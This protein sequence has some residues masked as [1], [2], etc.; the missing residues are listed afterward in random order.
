[1]AV[2]LRPNNKKALRK[3][4]KGK[5]QHAVS[6]RK[7]DELFVFGYGCKLF[8]DFEKA[9]FMEQ[10]KHLIEWPGDDSLLIDRY[11]GRLLFTDK[12]QFEPSGR[13]SVMTAEEIELEK[14]CDEERYLELTRDLLEDE[15]QQEE[16]MKRFKEAL[17]SDGAYNAVGF[18]YGDQQQG[19][20]IQDQGRASSFEDANEQTSMQPL[21]K[22][23]AV[24][25]F[26]APEDLEVPPGME[27]P[28]T[29][30]MNAI[31]EK[32]ALF[33][34]KQGTQMEILVKAKQAGNPQFDFLNFDNW[35]NPYYKHMLK[36][37]KEK[38]YEPKIQTQPES[39]EQQEEESEQEDS[40]DEYEL[41]PLLT[42]SLKT[43]A[44][45]Y[46]SAPSSPSTQQGDM[47]TQPQTNGADG[48]L[49]THP[50]SS[51]EQQQAWHHD[52]MAYPYDMTTT[53][54]A[55]P[56]TYP[57]LTAYHH[58]H[59]H[60]QAPPIMSVADMIPPPPPPPGEGP[61]EEEWLKEGVGSPS[62]PVTPPP[63]PPALPLIPHFL[64]DTQVAVPLG[65]PYP[66]TSHATPTIIPPPPDLQ[67]I[68][69]KLARYVA[70]NG[71]DFESIIKAKGDPRFDFVLPWNEHHA[72]YQFRIRTCAE[73]FAKEQETSGS[74]PKTNSVPISFSIKTKEIQ[75]PK[76]EYRSNVLYK[77]SFGTGESEEED[78][79]SPKAEGENSGDTTEEGSNPPSEPASNQ[80]DDN[81]GND[82]EDAVAAAQRVAERLELQTQTQVDKQLQLER[83]RKAS[84]FISMLKKTNEPENGAEDFGVDSQSSSSRRRFSERK[85]ENDSRLDGEPKTKKSKSEDVAT[86]GS[87][88]APSPDTIRIA[89]DLMAKVRAASRNKR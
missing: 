36:Y 88:G 63:P 53:S 65:V 44:S 46:S 6:G 43:T 32:T 21:P 18:G 28:D 47:L 11:D 12:S 2:F 61:P 33:V 15:I 13:P 27:I 59:H 76:I 31:I 22:P 84:L 67:P 26:I 42:A 3:D 24:E 29:A 9:E 35:L 81:E 87:V 5:Q 73:E 45:P 66:V 39:P 54:Y 51:H 38:R 78:E 23:E 68:V 62:N 25:K 7:D 86:N 37:I 50:V 30:K 74:D 55:V 49:Y 71:P 34:S 75:K 19:E 4:L 1:M 85:R 48:V 10:G 72:Y 20:H 17:S 60:I 41:H 16:E 64:P 14:L 83:R 40:D 69:D 70:K 89:Q 58:M 82:G 52:Q 77:Q 57:A 8:E 56:H 79:K 80:N